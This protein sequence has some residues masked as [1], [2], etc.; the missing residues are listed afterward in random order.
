V[1]AQK[2][3]EPAFHIGRPIQLVCREDRVV[4]RL[5]ERARRS[6]A[7]PGAGRSGPWPGHAGPR[8][9]PPMGECGTTF[10]ASPALAKSCRAG[11]PIPRRRAVP[12]ASQPRHGPA[13]AGRVVRKHQHPA[14]GR[15]RVR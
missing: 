2:L 11:S 12:A 7:G 13:G 10:L 14:G 5:P 8:L 3:L 6:G 1:L 15:C 4:E 9:Q